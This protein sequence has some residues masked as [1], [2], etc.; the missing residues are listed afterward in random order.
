MSSEDLLHSWLDFTNQERNMSDKNTWKII[1]TMVVLFCVWLGIRYKEKADHRYQIRVQYE[2]MQGHS[3]REH[4]HDLNRFKSGL[5][6]MPEVDARREARSKE[7]H[8]FW[9]A[10]RQHLD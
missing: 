5:I 4:D 6:S 8:D 10:N 7:I 1:A 9:E 2:S 3:D